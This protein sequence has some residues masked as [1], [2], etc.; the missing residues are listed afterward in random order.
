M[1]PLNLSWQSIQIVLAGSIKRA[2]DGAGHRCKYG[3]ALAIASAMANHEWFT[4]E[5]C[6]RRSTSE[7]VDDELDEDAA[8]EAK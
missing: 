2:V 1:R 7:T 5:I 6:W 4:G 3:P 8:E